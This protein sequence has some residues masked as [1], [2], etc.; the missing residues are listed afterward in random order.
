MN[1]GAKYVLPFISKN[2]LLGTLSYKP[3]N[4]KW[5][6]DINIH[7]FGVEQLPNTGDN[8]VAYQRPSQSQPYTTVNAQFT[9][10]LKKVEFYGGCENIFDFRQNQPIISWQNPFGQYFDTSSAWGPTTGRELYFGIRVE[11]R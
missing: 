8:P 6:T 4:N 10:T 1:N 2:T 9:Y 3:I 5:H 11:L 7:W